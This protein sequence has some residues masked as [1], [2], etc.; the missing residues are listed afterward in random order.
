[1]NETNSCIFLNIQVNYDRRLANPS[2]PDP[3]TKLGPM[4]RLSTPLKTWKTL[5]FLKFSGD[6]EKNID[7]KRDIYRITEKLSEAGQKKQSFG[8]KSFYSNTSYGLQ[9]KK[10]HK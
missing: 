1:M 3:I 8:I 6:R 2:F 4:F 10:L 5:R 9:Y 7:L